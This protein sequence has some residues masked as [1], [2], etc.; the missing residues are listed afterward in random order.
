MAHYAIAIFNIYELSTIPPGGNRS[1][2]CERK[3]E[4]EQKTYQSLILRLKNFQNY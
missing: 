3:R 4:R 2:K 1:L